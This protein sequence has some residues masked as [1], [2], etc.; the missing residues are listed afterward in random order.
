MLIFDLLVVVLVAVS[1]FGVLVG[2]AV[3]YADR[4]TRRE[5]VAHVWQ[6]WAD[7][8]GFRF[9]ATAGEWPNKTSPRVEGHA[10]WGDFQ[11]ETTQR[12]ERVSTRLVGWPRD[13]LCARVTCTTEPAIPGEKTGYAAFDAEFST[14]AVPRG[15]A[16]R[17]I[18]P[19]L[20]RALQAFAMGRQLRFEYERGHVAMVWPGEERSDARIDEALRL[21]ELAAESIER[22]FHAAA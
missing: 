21:V 7:R 12:G 2:Y 19:E 11:L 16:S 13:A 10:A 5:A 15:T 8:H 17:V 18:G 14:H 4:E 22:A 1:T 6:P 3:Y 9:V 20:A